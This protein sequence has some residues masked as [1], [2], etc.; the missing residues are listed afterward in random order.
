MSE[1]YVC[2]RC[3]RTQEGSA[4][5]TFRIGKGV[6]R[7]R[8]GEDRRLAEGVELWQTEPDL[9]EACVNDLRRWYREAGGDPSDISG[10]WNK[11]DE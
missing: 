6:P 2:D 4:Y 7:S 10:D 9:C 5:A 11:N 8:Q 3:G 1:G